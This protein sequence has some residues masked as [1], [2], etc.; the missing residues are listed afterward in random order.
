MR[1]P[2]ILS[3]LALGLLAPAPALASP[4]FDGE[5]ADIWHLPEGQAPQSFTSG[6]AGRT[7][8]TA[9]SGDA[10]Q[11]TATDGSQVLL[12]ADARTDAV[13]INDAGNSWPPFSDRGPAVALVGLD[14]PLFTAGVDAPGVDLSPA[15]GTYP[16]SVEVV[17]R[18]TAHPNLQGRVELAWAV[19]GGVA[20]RS[21]ELERVIPVVAGPTEITAWAVQAGV[22]SPRR[23]VTIRIDRAAGAARDGD[24]DGV[25]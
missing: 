2:W 12:P 19:D 15:T 14:G 17:I 8:A 9:R 4:V 23:S 21:A 1:T 7:T 25:P 11:V 13:L 16:G 5:A 24:R 20:R 22:E 18:A 10:V 3:L 6:A